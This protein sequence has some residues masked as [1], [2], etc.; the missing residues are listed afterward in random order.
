MQSA[1]NR[2][3]YTIKN[4]ESIR[5]DTAIGAF[6][7]L[8]LFLEFEIYKKTEMKGKTVLLKTYEILND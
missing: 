6:E 2:I 5:F 3:Y 1:S 7:M 4:N 8:D